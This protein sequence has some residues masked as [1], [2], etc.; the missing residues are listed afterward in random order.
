[1]ELADRFTDQMRFGDVTS[2][3]GSNLV[4]QR[5]HLLRHGDAA[6]DVLLGHRF[7]R[8]KLAL[9]IVRERLFRKTGIV[10]FWVGNLPSRVKCWQNSYLQCRTQ[11]GYTRHHAF[12]DAALWGASGEC[13]VSHSQSRRNP[14]GVGGVARVSA[15]HSP[16]RRMR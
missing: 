15:A 11:R 6:L 7:P 8:T 14:E 9:F 12:S 16:H 4:E 1:E 5:V 10:Q 13:D 3:F 2:V